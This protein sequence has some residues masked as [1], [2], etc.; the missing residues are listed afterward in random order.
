MRPALVLALGIL[1]STVAAVLVYRALEQPTEPTAPPPVVAAVK[2]T[3][4][5][6]AAAELP[7]GA[8]LTAEQMKVV[9]WPAGAQPENAFGRP[10]E[11]VGRMVTARVV[12]N[13]VLTV[14]KLAPT[15][16]NALLPVVIAPG[17]RAVTVRVNEVTAVSGFILPG[18]HVDVLVTADVRG[19]EGQAAPGR[20]TRTLL[21][22][23]SVLAVGQSLDSRA[24]PKPASTLTTA[25]LLATPEQAELLALASMDGS[26]Q[27]VLRNFADNDV[28]RSGGKSSDDL[29]ALARRPDETTPDGPITQV[30]LIRGSDR[31]VQTF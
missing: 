16:A 12:P 21:Q 7:L 20:H 11:L 23:V 25:T 29:F 22:N 17:M 18:S 9:N 8:L 24:E 14:D 4:I 27:L 30:E 1:V 10:E 19:T 31:A 28:V 15:G 3:P 2:T 6:V 13:E 5:V 26:L